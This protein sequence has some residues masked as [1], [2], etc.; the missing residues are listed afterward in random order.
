MPR[1]GVT[2]LAHLL[3]RT[4]RLNPDKEG[5]GTRELIRMVE[6]EKDVSRG[7]LSRRVSG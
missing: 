3:E 1:E 6:E 5:F 7:C 2:V 4:I